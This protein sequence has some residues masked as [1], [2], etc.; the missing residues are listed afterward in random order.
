LE[1]FLF[2]IRFARSA[3]LSLIAPRR[4]FRSA[5]HGALNNASR[6][7]AGEPG[8]EVDLNQPSTERR[9]SER[10]SESLP[11]IVRGIDLLGQPFEERTTTLAFNLH[12]CRYTSKHH[13]PR[14]TWVTLDLPQ[15]V[16][17]AVTQA[18]AGTNASA[19]STGD[20][21]T[22]LRARVAWVQRP[23]SI[24]D[25]FQIAVELESPA[26][27]W[28]SD[29]AEW[30]SAAAATP[31]SETLHARS[32]LRF[33]EPSATD[34]AT[35]NLG[36]FM[37]QFKTEAKIDSQETYETAE[38]AQELARETV[39]QVEAAPA[40]DNPLLRELRAELDRQAKDAVLAA[41]EQA[42]EEVLQTAAATVRERA[43]SA[44]ELFAKWKSEIEKLQAGACEEFFAQVAA[45]QD[46]A[47]GALQSGFDEKFGQAREL[48]G[49]IARQAEALR[50][51]SGNAQEA[52]SQVAR[53]LL[54]LEM[55]DTA[56]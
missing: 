18:N 1:C 4:A 38:P 22:T 28:G 53:A 44:E 32:I 34:I 55:A 51:E 6:K 54:Q 31:E 15:G 27:I 26:N 35:G 40:A 2:S 8:G 39:Q 7:P 29:A 48:L 36:N 25:F 17:Q 33:G 12:G 56:R 49:E 24:R 10:V 3:I 42:R 52:T 50:A 23:H 20:S 21:R 45:K 11:L 43:S 41:A 16:A 37:D 13:L 14:N 46:E 30:N 19:N 9:R 5:S 47:L